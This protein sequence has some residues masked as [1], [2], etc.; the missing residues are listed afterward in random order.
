MRTPAFELAPKPPKKLSGIEMTK[1]HGQEITRKV[2]A[3]LNHSGKSPTKSP[4]N[5]GG[6][7]AK[8]KAAITTV[9]V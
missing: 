8:I 1:A 4:E 3:R 6:K 2:S 9:G 5:T 7:K